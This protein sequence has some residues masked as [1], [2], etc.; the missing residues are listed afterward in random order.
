MSSETE[1]EDARD[2]IRRVGTVLVASGGFA[3]V[4]MA[5]AVAASVVDARN[6]DAEWDGLGLAVTALGV[7]LS[8]FQIVVGL[9]A[10]RLDYRSR[11][12]GLAVGAANAALFISAVIQAGRLVAPLQAAIAGVCAWAFWSPTSQ[13]LLEPRPTDP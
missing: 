11:V 12:A 8:L 9:L 1:R 10:R 2:T 3:L 4:V 6:T 7:L 13:Q 5:L